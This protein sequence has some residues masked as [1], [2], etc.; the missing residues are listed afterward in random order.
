MGCCQSSTK[1]YSQSDPQQ[2]GNK[3][4]ANNSYSSNPQAIHPQ[5][6][7][8]SNNRQADPYSTRSQEVKPSAQDIRL[9]QEI[10]DRFEISKLMKEKLENVAHTSDQLD[11]IVSEIVKS[12][13]KLEQI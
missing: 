6:N 1:G 9:L 11:S 4:G 12:I 8:P 2:E 13:I 3:S 10:L 5:T 7:S